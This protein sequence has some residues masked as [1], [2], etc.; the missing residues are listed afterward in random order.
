MGFDNGTCCGTKA[1]VQGFLYKKDG[2]K[3]TL[4]AKGTVSAN[5][6]YNAYVCVLWGNIQG[7]GA[8]ND[9]F[10]VQAFTTA[11]GTKET[12]W[13]SNGMYGLSTASGNNT[14]NIVGS[15]ADTANQRYELALAGCPQLQSNCGL[16]LADTD[17]AASVSNVLEVSLAKDTL[18]AND[19]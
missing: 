4:T 19:K 17:S 18:T 3:D 16:A 15:L 5:A 9:K 13:C 10:A 14:T 2:T 12:W 1:E 6:K 7:T 8:D 11:S